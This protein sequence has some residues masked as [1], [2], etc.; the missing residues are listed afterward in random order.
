MDNLTSFKSRANRQT[1]PNQFNGLDF[2]IDPRRW[3]N[4]YDLVTP[5]LYLADQIF[6]HVVLDRRDFHVMGYLVT[7]ERVSPGIGK[8]C[9]KRLSLFLQVP[10]SGR[11]RLSA[12]VANQGADP[13]I[14]IRQKTRGTGTVWSV[15]S[16]P[17]P[18][19]A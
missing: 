12:V 19:C 16:L 14:R 3:C 8:K 7:V 11:K 15:I 1:L 5:E 17:G 2:S 18:G 13:A 4:Q 9:L 10:T 6:A